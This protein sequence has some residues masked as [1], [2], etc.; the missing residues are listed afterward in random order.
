M[1]LGKTLCA[2]IKFKTNKKKMWYKYAMEY[3]SAIKNNEK[4]KPLQDFEQFIYL[5]EQ[6]LPCQR[7][8][9]INIAGLIQTE[10]K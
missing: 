4:K 10:I 6:F 2:P 8:N 7:D 1:G 9:K 3:Y 5:S